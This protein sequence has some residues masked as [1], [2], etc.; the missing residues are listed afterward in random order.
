M[1]SESDGPL[2]L[3]ERVMKLLVER[4]LRCLITSDS[5]PLQLNVFAH[6]TNKSFVP[7]LIKLWFI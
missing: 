1:A 6:W 5:S 2:Y 3:P 7:N 4:L